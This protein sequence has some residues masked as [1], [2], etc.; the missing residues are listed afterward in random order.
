M[1]QQTISLIALRLLAERAEDRLDRQDAASKLARQIA[2][3][4]RA[5]PFDNR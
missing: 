2:W 1:D 4:K 3:I 5:K